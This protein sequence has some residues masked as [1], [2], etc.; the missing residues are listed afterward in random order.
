MGEYSKL[1]IMRY[2]IVTFLL[3]FSIDSN[4]QNSKFEEI[5]L[6]NSNNYRN[7]L[8]LSD[9]A[10][11]VTYV[12]LETKDNCLIGNHYW[13]TVSKEYIFVFMSGEILQFSS[14]G[15]FIRQINKVGQ[16]PGEIFVRCFTIDEENQLIYAYHNYTH[17]I[18]VYNIDGKYLKTIRDPFKNEA[19][20]NGELH[21]MSIY[22]NNLMFPL[23]NDSGECPYKYIVINTEGEIIH[24]E[25]NYNKYS[26][27]K[28][29]QIISIPDVN[30]SPFVI[31]DFSCLLKQEFNDT[32]FSINPDYSNT[33]KYVIKLEKQLTLE[34]DQK[35]SASV[36]DISD[37]S[38]KNVIYGVTDSETYYYFYHNKIG[39]KNR[40]FSQYN[41]QTKQLLDNVNFE[42]VNDWDGG[43]DIKFEYKHQNPSV[44]CVPFWPSEMHEK[45]TN[46]HFSKSQAKYPEQKEELKKLLKNVK[47]EDNPVLMMIHLK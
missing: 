34:E 7:E 32:I 29:R 46:S 27:K 43:M 26:I 42:I 8:K 12:P 37:I 5:Q 39:I 41:K 35:L 14:N 20:V 38:G 2:I 44:M 10:K 3:L 33:P 1:N 25:I 36:I 21:L 24:K 15:K 13:V 30:S 23:G 9:I 40:F 18:Y 28:S 17:D 16:G 11:R 31:D 6:V 4:A 47:E 45:L 19:S 22:K